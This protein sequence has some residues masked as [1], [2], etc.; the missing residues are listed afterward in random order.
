MLMDGL[1]ALHP[2]LQRTVDEQQPMSMDVLPTLHPDLQQ[3][4]D[5]QQ[6]TLMLAP[7]PAVPLELLPAPALIPSPP[8]A[9]TSAV[10]APM[11]VMLELPTPSCPTSVIALTSPPATPPSAPNP[12]A[13][14]PCAERKRR[15][16]PSRPHRWFPTIPTRHACRRPVPRSTIASACRAQRKPGRTQPPRW[17]RGRRRHSAARGPGRTQ[18]L[19]LRQALPPPWLLH[20]P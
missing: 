10:A 8:S 15:R 20:Q 1:S 2:D 16:R 19:L 13:L 3:V 14:P 17:F 11:L 4:L 18:P 5:E 9:S 6:A 12:V 7:H